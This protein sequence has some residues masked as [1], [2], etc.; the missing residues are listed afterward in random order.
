MLKTKERCSI[1]R[2]NDTHRAYRDIP[3][4]G[5]KSFFDRIKDL[6]FQIFEETIKFTPIYN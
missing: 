5:I 1:L 6:P 2:E 4:Q 3:L